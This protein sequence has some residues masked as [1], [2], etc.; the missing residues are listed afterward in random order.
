[1]NFRRNVPIPLPVPAPLDAKVIPERASGPVD[2]VLAAVVIALIGFGV[3]MVYTASAVQATVQFRD[4]QFRSEPGLG[5]RNFLEFP[6]ELTR[7]KQHRILE[8]AHPARQRP[9]VEVAD[10]ERGARRDAGHQQHAAQDDPSN[11]QPRSPGAF[12]RRIDWPGDG[13]ICSVPSE[14]SLKN[15]HEGSPRMYRDR[16]G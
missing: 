13:R 7:H 12:A 1:M 10:H 14:Q 15:R 4:P 16:L 9:F 8:L 2:P 6:I 3:V 11:R 5:Y